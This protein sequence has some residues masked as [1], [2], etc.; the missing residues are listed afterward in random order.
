MS[1]P[2]LDVDRRARGRPDL[3]TL[4]PAARRGE[5]EAS[6]QLLAHVRHMAHRY[7][8]ARLGTYPAAAQTADDVAQEVCI[9]VLS[10]LPGYEDRGLP[11]EAFVYRVAS[12]KVA[13]ARR[14]HA[15]APVTAD[16][17]ESPVFDAEVAGPEH[18]VVERDEASRA[19]SMLDHLSARQRDVLVLRVAVGL[20]VQETADTLDI[21]AVSVRVTQLRA[22]RAL[23][24]RW[25][26]AQA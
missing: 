18:H 22:I 4:V 25:D 1:L 10:A 12:H 21:S 7:A 11:F 8:G 26:Q 9:A 19:W 15:Q 3:G 16:H 24:A 14:A 17:V 2:D 5:T 13:D 6:T 23:R 20:S